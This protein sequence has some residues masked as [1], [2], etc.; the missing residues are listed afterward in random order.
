MT[1]SSRRNTCLSQCIESARL[2]TSRAG[3]K[4]QVSRAALLSNILGINNDAKHGLKA[5]QTS[6]IASS[7]ILL[8][9]LSQAKIWRCSH[10]NGII[11]HHGM[12]FLHRRSSYF[13]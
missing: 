5:A 3:Y 9:E 1:L 13:R 12:F 6:R 8:S 7:R 4:I 10:E 11:S 2:S